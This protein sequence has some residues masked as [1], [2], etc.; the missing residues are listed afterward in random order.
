[1]SAPSSFKSIIELWPTREAMA[2]ALGEDLR[3]ISKWWQRDRIPAER[4]EHILALPTVADAGL[5]AEHLIRLAARRGHNRPNIARH[6]TYKRKRSYG[7]SKGMRP[8]Y[9][10]S[11]REIGRNV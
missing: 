5:T 3:L 9:N 8:N 6:L 11:G 2:A 7:S 4:W 1:M 10:K